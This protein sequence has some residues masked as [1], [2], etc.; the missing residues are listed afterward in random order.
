M[1]MPMKKKVK[2]IDDLRK[3]SKA[4]EEGSAAEEAT[5]SKDEESKED[6]GTDKE[7]GKGKGQ[8]SKMIKKV[9]P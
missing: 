4:M 3:M 7:A 9:K 1:K 5:E 2:S 6:K 8:L